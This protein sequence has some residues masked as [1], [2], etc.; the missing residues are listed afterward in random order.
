MRRHR[1]I[2][3]AA[4]LLAAAA[5]LLSLGDDA[6]APA[7]RRTVD[8]PQ[9]FD[10]ADQERQEARAT[11]A[12]PPAPGAPPATDSEPGTE[13]GLRD[14]FLVSL[15]V[16]GEGLVVV[17]EA[18]ALRHSRLGERFIAC[19]QAADARALAEVQTETGIDPLKDLDRVAFL[20]DA[21][22]LSGYFENVRWDRIKSPPLAYGQGGRIYQDGSDWIATWRDQ[23]IVLSES[24][25]TARRAIDQLEGRAPVPPS[26][27]GEDLTYG[28]VYGVI[29]GAS[30]RRL[31]GADERGI[32]S[33]LAELAK[34]VELHVDAMDDVAAVIRVQGD[35]R[36]G[37]EDL[38]KT[39]GAALAVARVKAQAEG[40][41]E[42]AELLE[43]AEVRPSG[44][45][46]SVKFAVPADRLDQW[47]AHCGRPPTTA[48]PIDPEPELE[49]H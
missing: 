40:D 13:Q 24:E 12:L 32:G 41:R 9:W 31:L 22:V 49:V 29:P 48:A 6:P 10:A 5:L 27:V 7:P 14:P 35:D 37:I 30:A 3:L 42:L 20:D 16:K 26:S 19:L 23:L 44:G 25:E 34:R 8:Y 36:S 38:A 15:P 2:V 11:L 17:F 28:E 45:A 21:V 4:L 46:F 33:K 39:I 43:G 47:F 18:N 1:W